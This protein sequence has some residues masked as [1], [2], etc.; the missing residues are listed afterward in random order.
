M[1]TLKHST[2]AEYYGYAVLIVTPGPEVTEVRY[3][4]HLGKAIRKEVF[5]VETKSLKLLR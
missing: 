4:G 1:Q 3:V 5:E 2:F